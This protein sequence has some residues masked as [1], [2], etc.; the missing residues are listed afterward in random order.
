MPHETQRPGTKLDYTCDWGTWLA[1]AGS[2]SDTI[3][4]STWEVSPDDGSPAPVISDLSI[5]GDFATAWLS[6]LEE[7]NVYRLRNRVVSAQGRSVSRTFTIRC[8]V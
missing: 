4:G 8:G 7:G 6:E 2:P 1:D 5:V 3:T